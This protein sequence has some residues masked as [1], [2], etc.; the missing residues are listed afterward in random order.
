MNIVWIK[1]RHAFPTFRATLAAGQRWPLPRSDIARKREQ[2]DRLRQRRVAFDVAR[3]PYHGKT[4]RKPW[5]N[6]GKTMRKPWENHGK[7]MA[8]P[9]ENH[10]KT[11]RKPWENHG[12]IM[13]KPWE[14]HG[15][16]MRKPWE[17]HAKMR[18]NARK[19]AKYQCCLWL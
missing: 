9:C 2:L 8:K 3:R 6:H 16:T 19:T 12:K 10:G 15:K 7:I 14:N 4:M 1:T 17:N 5:E 18:M 13:G 11:M